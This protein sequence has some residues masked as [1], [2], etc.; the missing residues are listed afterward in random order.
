MLNT[1]KEHP[2]RFRPCRFGKERKLIE[3]LAG[4]GLTYLRGDD[5]YQYRFFYCT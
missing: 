4:F 1:L 5:P 3:V 2:D